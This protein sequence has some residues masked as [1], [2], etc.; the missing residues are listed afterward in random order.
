MIDLDCRLQLV[1][2]QRT[3]PELMDA[4]QPLE[5]FSKIEGKC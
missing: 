5:V 3:N 1:V 4:Q 2:V